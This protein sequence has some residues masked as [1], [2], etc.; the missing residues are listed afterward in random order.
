MGVGSTSEQKKAD[1]HDINVP[2]N[3]YERDL[4]RRSSVLQLYKNITVDLFKLFEF[5]LI[6]IIIFVAIFSIYNISARETLSKSIELK[7]NSLNSEFVTSNKMVLSSSQLTE[8]DQKDVAEQL[9][10]IS[11]LEILSSQIQ[12]L[13]AYGGS[14]ELTLNTIKSEFIVGN[15]AEADANVSLV[16]SLSPVA[17]L[18]R[19]FSYMSSDVLLAFSLLSCGAL[20]A[21][22]ASIRSNN[23]VDL[24]KFTIGFATGFVTFLGIKGGQFVFLLQVPGAASVLNPYTASFIGLLSGMFSERFHLMLADFLDKATNKL[25]GS[26]ENK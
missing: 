2:K 20:G 3:E 25:K 9:K 24:S 13:K 8:Q 21:V 5:V 14:D 1:V 19:L 18:V 7:I 6:C 10:E 12:A 17:S 16:I 15:R 4:E 11:N 23:N 22:I 26:D